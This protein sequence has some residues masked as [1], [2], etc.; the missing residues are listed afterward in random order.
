LR[1]VG[2]SFEHAH[3]GDLLR[4][5]Y[6]NPNA[7]IAGVLDND[8]PRMTDAIAKFSIPADPRL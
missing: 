5:A 3:I 1:I 7:E 4:E 6:E 2:S 8:K